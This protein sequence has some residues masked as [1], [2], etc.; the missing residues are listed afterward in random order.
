MPTNIPKPVR[1][2]APELLGAY[3]ARIRQG[4][5]L[6]HREEISLSRRAQRGNTRARSELV[7]RNL[8]LVV[9]VA[10]KYQHQG[11]PFE[12]LIQ[13]GNI[14]LMAAVDKFDPDKGYRFSTYAT[15]WI[16]QAV[17]RSVVNTGRSIRLP[18]HISEKLRKVRRAQGEL[19]AELGREPTPEEISTHVGWEPDEVLYVLGAPKETT[20][21]NKPLGAEKG[22][23]EIGDHIEDEHALYEADTAMHEEEVLGLLKAIED[24]PETSRRVLIRRYGLDTGK[25]ATLK[26][27]G[28]ELGVSKERVRQIQRESERTL[29][30]LLLASAEAA[31]ANHEPS[32]EEVAA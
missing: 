11:L 28:D 15:W 22:A 31:P 19:T 10:K 23:A 20:S 12:D 16:R 17:Q 30:N 7:E 4:E 21:L 26:E 1:E 14:G 27:L 8:R 5:L 13:E 32:D 9:S 6:S 24:L 3:M 29:R 25:K 18:N 2:E